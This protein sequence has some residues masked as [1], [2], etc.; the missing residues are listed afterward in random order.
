MRVERYTS[1][2][3]YNERKNLVSKFEY[4]IELKTSTAPS[5]WIP[6]TGLVITNKAVRLQPKTGGRLGEFRLPTDWGQYSFNSVYGAFD[7][8]SSY[9]TTYRYRARGTGVNVGHAVALAN[10]RTLNAGNDLFMPTLFTN[11]I[12]RARTEALL[13]LQQGDFNIGQ[14]LGESIQTVGF[15]AQSVVKLARAAAAASHGNWPKV[16][17]VLGYKPSIGSGAANTWLEYMYGW[18][19]LVND[20]YGAQETAK[21]GF[22]ERDQLFNVTR[23][24]TDHLPIA[25]CLSRTPRVLSGKA[26][27]VCKVVYWQ[28]ISDAKLAA[29]QS[30]GLVNPIAIAWELTT[31][32]FV[33]DWLIP[34]ANFLS[35]LTATLGLTFVSGY[36][37]RIVRYDI[38][39]TD[40]NHT[41]V[42]G[43]APSCTAEYHCFRRQSKLTWDSPNFYWKN[44]FSLPHVVSAIA[45]LRSLKR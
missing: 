10:W 38:R 36:E 45:L 8:D 35:A 5:A 6:S 18:L 44:P 1:A 39:W 43:T 14:A 22:L 27:E 28:K 19:P 15:L 9:S 25:S 33:I 7:Y 30:L 24:I 11:T 37:D 41:F 40:W 2:Y 21:K 4:A 20:I 16:A 26:S 34:V 17:R 12:N 3:G 23:E 29:L 31:Y 13:K 42:R 32:S